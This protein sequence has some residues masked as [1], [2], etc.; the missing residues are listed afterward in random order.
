MSVYIYQK[1]N[2][3]HFTWNTDLIISLLSEARNLQGRLIGKMELLGFDLRNEALLDTLTLD[4]LKSSEIEG[5][6]LN[7]DQVR[8]SIARKLGMDIA[9]SIESDRNVDGIVEMMFDATQNCF[10]PLSAERFFDWHAAL[11][12]TGRSGMYKIRVADWRK[13]TTGPMQVVSGAMGKEKVHFQAPDSGLVDNEMLRFLNWFNSDD[14]TDLVIKAAIAHLWFVTIHPF[15][16]GNG[17]ITRAL[18]DMILA[19]ADKSNQRFYSMSAQIRKERRGY[20]EILEKTQK[21][22]L[23]ITEWITWFLNCLIIALKSTDS[24]LR[25]VLFKADFWNKHSK[26]IINERQRKQ[27]N[28]LLDGFDGKLTSS[29]WAKIAKCSKDTAIRDINDLINKNILR[30][31]AAGGRST[32][33]ELVK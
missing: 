9:G 7:P 14:K 10:E 12:P 29:K 21:G 5:E 15:E 8:S 30:K 6:I 18:S 27:I 33:Y 3:P 17:R 1:D 22:N 4:V 23:D 11:F 32:N 19:R 16:D 31:E 25:Q 26:T 2:W 20:Y 28:K 24:I 13:D